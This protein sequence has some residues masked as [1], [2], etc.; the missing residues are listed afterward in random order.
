[1]ERFNDK[2]VSGEN[3]LKTITPERI[4]EEA[5]YAKLR[6]GIGR[7]DDAIYSQNEMIPR[8]S[9][10]LQLFEKLAQP[11]EDL[12]VKGREHA[13]EMANEFF[14]H[15][16]PNTDEIAIASSALTRSRQTAAIYLEV[17]KEKGFTVKIIAGDD[18]GN[19]NFLSQEEFEKLN[20]AKKE[21]HQSR[22][23]VTK[24]LFERQGGNEIRTLGPLSLD[25]IKQMFVEFIFHQDN[26]MNKVQKKYLEK[27]PDGYK[28]LW[29]EARKIIEA[30]NK[31]S[32]GANFLE[33]SEQLQRLFDEHKARQSSDSNIIPHFASVKDMYEKNFRNTLYLMERYDDAIDAYEADHPRHKRIRVLGFSHENQLIYFLNKEFNRIGAEKGKII[34]FRILKDENGRKH[35]ISCL[36][37]QPNDPKE[38][39]FPAAPGAQQIANKKNRGNNS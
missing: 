6:Y 32:W 23:Q 26:Y 25:N 34:G 29:A 20:Q 1:M 38:I 13:Y 16:N 14:N 3:E 27:I 39:S 9:E 36:P 19:V 35:F 31:G 12:S 10:P 17:A 33:Y 7:H 4:R 22:G 2:H 28:E 11:P 15:F 30:D 37:D 18:H 21:F 24:E 5:S 8:S